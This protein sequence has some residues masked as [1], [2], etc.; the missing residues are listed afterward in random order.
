MGTVT[1]LGHSSKKRDLTNAQN[2]G[3]LLRRQHERTHLESRG[4]PSWW[5]GLRWVSGDTGRAV[6]MTQTPSR[7][8]KQRR[9]RGPWGLR[10]SVLHHARTGCQPPTLVLALCPLSSSLLLRFPCLP[11]LRPCQTF[12]FLP[13]RF[14]LEREPRARTAA[15]VPDPTAWI[16]R[17][18]LSPRSLRN[19][20]QSLDY[21]PL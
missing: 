3:S 13:S 10:G 8:V 12:L 16:S 11:V 21:L 1:G 4:P 17:S 15:L 14:H 20:G 9:T 5:G 7:L 18:S 19:Q 6:R 2:Q